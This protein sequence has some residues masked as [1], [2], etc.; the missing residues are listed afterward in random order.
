MELHSI[1]AI[2]MKSENMD[3]QASIVSGVA[4]LNHGQQMNN[5]SCNQAKEVIICNG[6]YT[7][8]FFAIFLIILLRI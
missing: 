1:C 6:E 2:D 8:L 4:T 5:S 3:I 7:E